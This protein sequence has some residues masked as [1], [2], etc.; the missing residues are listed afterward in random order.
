MAEEKDVLTI[1]RRMVIASA[2]FVPLAALTAS[3]QQPTAAPPVFHATSELVQVNVVALDKHGKPVP[4]LRREEFQLFDNGVRQEIRLF[5][6]QGE[7]TVPR[8]PE[9]SAVNTF[10]NLI[11][12]SAGPQSGYTVILLDNLYSGSDPTNEEG[13]VLARSRA[14]EMLRSAPAG[15]KIAIYA[16]GIKFKV[17]CEFTTDRDLLERELRKFKVT[18]STPAPEVRPTLQSL[19]NPGAAPETQSH[20]A[21]EMARVDALI[22]SDIGDFQLSALADHV[23]GVPGRKKLI[24]LA[25]KFPISPQ[26]LQNLNRS[27]V[28]IYPVDIDGVC[29]LCPDRPRAQMDSIAAM[30]G[31]VPYYGRN[32]ISAAMLEAMDDGNVSYRLGF[33]PSV[34]EASADEG[35]GPAVHRLTVSV[36]R[37]G[38]RLRYGTT[39]QQTALPVTVTPGDLGHAMNRP[40]DATAIPVK[41]TVT[42]VRDRLS[43]DATVSVESLG[44]IPD[45]D[46]RTGKIEFAA[47]FTTADAVIASEPVTRTVTFNLSQEKYD[48][49]VRDG[50]TYHHELQIPSKAVELKL[51]FANPASGKIGTLTIP[52][53]R[54]KAGAAAPR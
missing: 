10:T 7:R 53:A 5:T 23:A 15:E 39:Y 19:L 9:L 24:W 16:P 32:D 54:V 42:R 34:D 28:S 47:R 41:A 2:M 46:R 3:A 29:R 8:P 18:P 26:A 17:I 43:L 40:I 11:A 6:G 14:L 33:Y 44:L 13:S 4:D 30:T 1:I 31:G 52:L 38:V 27:G 12:P 49:A 21:A 20:A 35:A 36:S 45:Q 25:N 51:L 37:L 50:I 22:Q 48:I